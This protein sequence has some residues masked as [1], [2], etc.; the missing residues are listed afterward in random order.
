MGGWDVSVARQ[1]MIPPAHLTVKLGP[2][3]YACVCVRLQKRK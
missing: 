1:H 3:G 2:H